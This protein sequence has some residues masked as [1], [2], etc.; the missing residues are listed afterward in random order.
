MQ[1]GKGFTSIDEYIATF[2][3]EVQQQLQ[4]MRETIRAEAPQATERISYQMP[5]FYQ[6]GNLVHFAAL[7]RHIGFYPTSSGVA[8]FERELGAYAS[9]KGAIQ[10]PMDQPLPLDLVRRITRFRVRE[11]QE[12]A[13]AKAGK[14]RARSTRRRS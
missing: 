5:T 12:R 10:F 1:P 6:H 4:T 8:A 7:K 2:L 11:N 14:E 3:P 13:A 9:T